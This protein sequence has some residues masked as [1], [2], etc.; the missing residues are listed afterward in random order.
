MY[1]QLERGVIKFDSEF[2]FFNREEGL[3]NYIGQF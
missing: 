2:S 3:L 1:I